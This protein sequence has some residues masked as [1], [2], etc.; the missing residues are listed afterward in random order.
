MGFTNYPHNKSNEIKRSPILNSKP[1]SPNKLR[2][3]SVTFTRF[4]GESH[5][6]TILLHNESQNEFLLLSGFIF[7]NHESIKISFSHNKNIQ[8]QAMI[9]ESHTIRRNLNGPVYVSNRMPVV[10]RSIIS[11]LFSSEAEK[12]TFYN[13]F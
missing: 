1:S 2:K 9:I 6:G 3:I 12:A 7:S 5:G 13:N 11:I 10:Q 8:I 4:N